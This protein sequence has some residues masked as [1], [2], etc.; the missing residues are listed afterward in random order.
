G[1]GH[2]KDHDL[3]LGRRVLDPGDGLEP[4]ED[5]HHQVEEDGIGFVLGHESYR[6]L[7]V[8]GLP[9]Y[10][11]ATVPLEGHA[12]HAADVVRVVGE[13]DSYGHAASMPKTGRPIE[14]GP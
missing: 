10:V 5:G 1:G 12:Q 7:T 13:H 4:V 11:E 6:F 9:D 14:T 2:R 3:G 8:G